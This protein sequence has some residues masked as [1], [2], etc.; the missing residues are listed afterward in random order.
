MYLLSMLLAGGVLYWLGLRGLGYLG[1]MFI[2]LPATFWLVLFVTVRIA[3]P[4]IAITGFVRFLEDDAD[5]QVQ[6]VPGRA[7]EFRLTNPGW[8]VEGALMKTLI[9]V[10]AAY[11]LWA[12]ANAV[13]YLAMPDV[14]EIRNAQNGFAMRAE[15]HKNRLALTNE[16]DLGWT[17]D[18]RIGAGLPL[19]FRASASLPPGVTREIRYVDFRPR[20][21]LIEPAELRDSARREINV[22]CREPSGLSRAALLK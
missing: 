10:C 19:T 5:D 6:P 4:E 15:I 11:M 7:P 22:E 13:L 21:F 17:C 9:L 14:A 16:S 12:A 20:Y 3:S 8:M 1:L 2:I 18:V